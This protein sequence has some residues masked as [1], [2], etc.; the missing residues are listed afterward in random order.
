MGAVIRRIIEA[1][2]I[3]RCGAGYRAGSNPPELHLEAILPL[4]VD[5]QLVTD[6]RA[7][8]WAV[9]VTPTK[10]VLR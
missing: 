1:R 9:T 5:H 4:G 8:G 2:G 3:A 6:L 7:A 10:D